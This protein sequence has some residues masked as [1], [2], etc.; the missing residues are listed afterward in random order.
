MALLSDSGLKLK[1]NFYRCARGVPFLVRAISC[2]LN[3]AWFGTQVRRL[4]LVTPREQDRAKRTLIKH[5]LALHLVLTSY[6]APSN[7]VVSSAGFLGTRR[8]AT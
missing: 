2:L 7:G 1:L 4:S 6:G 8:L 3:L 5:A